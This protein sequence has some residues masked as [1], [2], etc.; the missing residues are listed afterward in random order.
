MHLFS[1]EDGILLV[2]VLQRM[3]KFMTKSLFSR[4]YRSCESE[5][6]RRRRGVR[7]D[8][9]LSHRVCENMR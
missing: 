8:V 3:Y 5:C 9:F 2:C 7:M 4:K 6:R 1:T